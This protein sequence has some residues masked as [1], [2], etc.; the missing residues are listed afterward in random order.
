MLPLTW[1]VQTIRRCLTSGFFLKAAVRQEDGLYKTLVGNKVPPTSAPQQAPS[2]SLFPGQLAKI[3]PSSVLFTKKPLCV[4][5]NQLV[6]SSTKLL[7]PPDH[8]HLTNRSVMS[9]P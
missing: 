7:L 6:P 1:R 8:A 5:Y 2:R 3:H 4:L 9:D